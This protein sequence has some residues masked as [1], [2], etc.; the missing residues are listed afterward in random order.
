MKCDELKSIHVPEENFCGVVEKAFD[1]YETEPV[2]AAIA[3]LKQKL[4]DAEM[5]ADLAEAA[6]TEY[7]LHPGQTEVSPYYVQVPQSEYKSLKRENQQLHALLHGVKGQDSNAEIDT[8]ASECRAIRT[9]NAKLQGIKAQL[10][11]DVALLRKN[12][13]EMR[14]ATRWRKCSEELPPF[15]GDDYLVTNGT[16]CVVCEWRGYWNNEP[17]L[18]DKVNENVEAWMFMPK[19]PEGK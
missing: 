11:E 18:G 13:D 10:E 2:D 14:E 16:Y 7:R 5:M 8:L 6:N 12:N 19:A 15:E 1:Y 3:E 4:H 9:M 17:F